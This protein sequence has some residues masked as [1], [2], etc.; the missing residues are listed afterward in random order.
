MRRIIIIIILVSYIN[1]KAMQNERDGEPRPFVCVAP[2]RTQKWSNLQSSPNSMV[3]QQRAS[4]LRSVLRK[5]TLLY[6]QECYCNQCVAGHGVGWQRGE[7]DQHKRNPT[8][9]KNKL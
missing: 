6:G 5:P 1:M 2:D 3:L 8:Y 7:D 4:I 9:R